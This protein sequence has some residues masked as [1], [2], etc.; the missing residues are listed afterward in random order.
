MGSGVSAKEGTGQ[1]AAN[2]WSSCFSRAGR[3]QGPS[4]RKRI[5]FSPS[6]S[7][8]ESKDGHETKPH[9]VEREF[10]N[11]EK[12]LTPDPFFGDRSSPESRS[13]C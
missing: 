2:K 3:V 6:T 1:R 11:L 4:A 13:D 8:G 7:E 10:E 5:N 12:I 9:C